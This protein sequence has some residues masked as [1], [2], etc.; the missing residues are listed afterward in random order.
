MLVVL[1]QSNHLAWG[2]G[3]VNVSKRV[4]GC[5]IVEC[6][7]ARRLYTSICGYL[8]DDG[9][10]NGLGSG[11]DASDHEANASTTTLND[12]NVGLVGLASQGERRPDLGRGGIAGVVCGVMGLCRRWGNGELRLYIDQ[13]IGSQT[14]KR[15]DT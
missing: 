14:W 5:R 10:Q 15:S 1:V 4:G 11:A 13:D 12:A 7:E 3:G 9:Q 6:G 8:R 2:G